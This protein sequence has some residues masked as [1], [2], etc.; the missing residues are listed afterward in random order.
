MPTALPVTIVRQ[1][2]AWWLVTAA[3]LAGLGFS[4]DGVLLAVG[5]APAATVAGGAVTAAALGALLALPVS[6]ALAV[7]AQVV[8][9]TARRL[10]R[11]KA[12]RF[13]IPAAL[14]LWPVWRV[15]DPTADTLLEYAP[16]VVATALAIGLAAWLSRAQPPGL[17]RVAAGLMAASAVAADV[18]LSPSMYLELH[19]LAHIVAAAGCLAVATRVRERIAAARPLAVVVAALVVP[20]LGLGIAIVADD[21]APGWRAASLRH[22]RHASRLA[23]GLRAVV[24]RDRDGYS[25][26]AWGGDCDDGD[27]SRHPAAPDPPGGGDSNCNGVD[28]P[29]HPGED[30]FG[31]APAR[32][33]P[34]A[35]ADE[36][37]LV[38]FITID[39]IRADVAVPELMPKLSAFA[40]RGVLFEWAYAAGSSTKESLPLTQRSG[41]DAPLLAPTLAKA[42]VETSAVSARY[43]MGIA[44]ESLGYAS[45][46]YVANDAR[47]I[48][49]AAIARMRA[50]GE[51]RHLLWVHYYDP[52]LPTKVRADVGVPEARP[53]LPDSYRSE[54]RHVDNQLGRLFDALEADGR[55]ARAAVVITGDH[56]EGFGEHGIHAHGRTGYDFILRVPAV[57]VAPGVRPGRYRH[58]VT[59][60]DLPATFLGL[61]GLA[62]RSAE[63]ERVGRS[64]LRLRT[65]PDDPLHEFVV[66]RS[67][68]FSSGRRTYAK[69]GVLVRADGWKL[70]AG[71]EE[72]VFELYNLVADPD[73]NTDRLADERGIGED[74]WRALALYCDLDG[75]PR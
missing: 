41:D 27:A 10:P 8:G 9:V 32:G 30:A 46:R 12:W 56:G 55:I 39:T 54:L 29:E 17:A 15:L 51:Q 25:P 61:F 52:H 11:P 40:K 28:P 42:G 24:D 44:A 59:H 3:V 57:F 20:A 6:I 47:A 31:L 2:L 35:R 66:A 13:A 19:E 7:V 45:V 14:A 50:L 70:V 21:V 71:L 33:K 16:F 64:W 43:R 75:Y 67:H 23:R 63:A 5:G 53:D 58:L 48:T 18:W 74:L 34:Y 69:L 72:Q 49:D 73:E 60:R 38:L 37:D 22:G 62:D 26:I 65:A 36:V 68:R 4:V 1:L